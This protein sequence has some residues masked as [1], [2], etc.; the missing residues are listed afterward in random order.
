MGGGKRR[1]IILYTKLVLFSG[2]RVSASIC[3]AA[4]GSWDPGER[5]L[6][7]HMLT[8]ARWLNGSDNRMLEPHNKIPNTD[9]VTIR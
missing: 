9:V 8:T 6:L 4:D 1:Y 2:F 3:T 5:D 7:T